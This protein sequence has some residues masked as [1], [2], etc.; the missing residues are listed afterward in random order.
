[1]RVFGH[2][3]RTG[4]FATINGFAIGN[5][6]Q[7]TPAYS[8]TNLTLN[9][10]AAA[11]IPV[12]PDSDGRGSL[13][14][15]IAVVDM[16]GHRGDYWSYNQGTFIG[17]LVALQR[18]TG[19]IAYLDEAANVAGTVLHQSGLILPDGVIFEKIDTRGDAC[20]F[21]GIFARYLA[22][23]LDVL[24]DRGSHGELAEEI[25]RSLRASAAAF[26]ENGVGADGLYPAEWHKGARD[27]RA[28]FNTQVSAL[29]GLVALLPEAKR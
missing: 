28:N 25:E 16:P 6:K 10:F 9:V 17:A 11:P 7:F 19:K 14:D 5:G 18:A 15:G 8:A 3:S 2:G 21:K 1:M 20:L 23:F 27:T 29:A 24:R 12:L 13:Y 26:I 4:Q 22:Q